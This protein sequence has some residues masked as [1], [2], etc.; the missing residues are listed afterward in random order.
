MPEFA[1]PQEAAAYTMLKQV[2][3]N[4]VTLHRMSLL[5]AAMAGVGLLGDC[6]VAC[7]GAGTVPSVVVSETLARLKRRVHIQQTTPGLAP[8]VAESARDPAAHLGEHSRH[9]YDALRQLFHESSDA[10]RLDRRGGMRVVL[11]LMADVLSMF[12]HQFDQ[13]IAEVDVIIDEVV[14]PSLESY[15]KTHLPFPTSG[16]YD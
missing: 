8:F 7:C 4:H 9:L 12:L 15:L 3:Q 16:R 10:Q 6:C 2:L 5:A 13:T 1:T 11:G 14:G